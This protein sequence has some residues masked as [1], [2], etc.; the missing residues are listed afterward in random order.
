MI[1]HRMFLLARVY[2]YKFYWLKFYIHTKLCKSSLTSANE[3]FTLCHIYY[4]VFRAYITTTISVLV[5]ALP[6]HQCSCVS[7]RNGSDGPKSFPVVSPAELTH[8]CW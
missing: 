7:I 8:H 4:H 1:Q 6:L 3:T 5:S 2:D